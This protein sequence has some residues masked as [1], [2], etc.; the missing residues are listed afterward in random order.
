MSCSCYE[1]DVR[2]SRPSVCSQFY[3][4]KWKWTHNR[5]G[6]CDL[7][8]G[9]LKPSRIVISSDP[10]V[11]EIALGITLSQQ[12]TLLQLRSLDGSTVSICE[13][14]LPAWCLV[15]VDD[16]VVV[17]TDLCTAMTSRLY[18]TALSKTWRHSPICEYW[19]LTIW[20]CPSDLG[21]VCLSIRCTPLYWL[22]PILDDDEHQ[23]IWVHRAKGTE[24]WHGQRTFRPLCPMANTLV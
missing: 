1:H 9:L 15:A 18:R 16:V 24:F 3:N 11:P 23:D 2:L 19:V 8:T 13:R 5:I 12:A 14:V 4:K 7:A 21:P 20:L 22:H 6:Q 10:E 17:S